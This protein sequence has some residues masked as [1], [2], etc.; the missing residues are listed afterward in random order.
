MQHQPLETQAAVSLAFFLSSQTQ[1][2][3]IEQ[4]QL[5]RIE[6]VYKTFMIDNSNARLILKDSHLKE[7]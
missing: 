1:H 6:L 3:M 2:K 7:R 4:D 5:Y